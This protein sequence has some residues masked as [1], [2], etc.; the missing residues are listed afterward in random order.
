MNDQKCGGRKSSLMSAIT[1]R[2]EI[3]SYFDPPPAGAIQ[4]RD[5]K[6]VTL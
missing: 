5:K 6:D 2:D 4:V 3:E 1:W